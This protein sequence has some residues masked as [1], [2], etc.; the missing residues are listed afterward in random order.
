MNARGSKRKSGTDWRFLASDSDEGID[1][2]EIPELGPDFWKK[3]VLRTPQKKENLTL[4]LD[5]DVV[6]WFRAM[7]RGYQA[8]MNAVLRSYMQATRQA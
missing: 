1:F 3:A 6:A 7:G 4:R 5:Q 8:K 2:T